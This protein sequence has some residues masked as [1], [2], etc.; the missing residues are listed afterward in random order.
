MCIV[1]SHRGFCRGNSAIENTTE[2]IANAIAFGITD[3]EFDIRKTVDD[4]FVVSHDDTIYNL[5]GELMTIT[6]A[7]YD[8]LHRFESSV[9][10]FEELLLRMSDVP[11]VQ[12]IRFILD[13]KTNDISGR[14]IKLLDD[15][16]ARFPDMT[17]VYTSFNHTVL[18]SRLSNVVDFGAMICHIPS[19]VELESYTYHWLGMSCEDVTEDIVTMV[20]SVGKILYVYTPN[21]RTMIR[22]LVEWGVDAIYTDSIDSAVNEL[23]AVS[24]VRTEQPHE[25]IHIDTF[26]T[27]L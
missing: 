19:V 15:S 17:F 3:I 25:R 27:S 12:P 14:F 26:V 23:Y 18:R 1:I 5:A 20:H 9:E 8:S 7:T 13:I 2:S 16:V 6:T 10:R 21:S 22:R 11:R 4:I 24:N